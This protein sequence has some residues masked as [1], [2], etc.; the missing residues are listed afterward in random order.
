MQGR[1]DQGSLRRPRALPRWGTRVRR[2]PGHAAVGAS[3]PTPSAARAHAGIR[4]DR[5]PRVRSRRIATLQGVSDTM[6]AIWWIGRQ[7]VA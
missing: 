7:L 6:L 5:L 4:P 1:Q 3:A 2:Q